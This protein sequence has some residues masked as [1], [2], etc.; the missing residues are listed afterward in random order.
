MTIRIAIVGVGWAGSRHAEAISELA[1]AAVGGNEPRLSLQ[2]LVDNDPAHLS[3]KATEFA[4]ESTSTDLSDA[5]NSSD[6][7]AVSIATPHDLHAPQA[8]AAAQAGKHVIV[9]KPMA[10]TV[11]D[12]TRMIDAADVNGVK[13]YVAENVTYGAMTLTLKELVRAQ[14]YTGPLT[15][16]TVIAGFRAESYGFP[17]RRAWLA[18]PSAGGSGTWLLH[19]VHTV[20]Q[21][22]AV[23]GD[24]ASVYVQESHT[25]DFSSPELE[26]TMSVLLTMESG[27]SVLFV[28]S[29]ETRFK[30]SQIGYTL[31][32]ERGSIRADRDR[33]EV[34]ST[35]IDP[36]L[37]EPL[38]L[39]Y[40]SQG[41]SEYALEFEAFAD[42][43]EHGA[44]GPTTGREERKS[45]AIVQAGYES[46]DIGQPINLRER[47]GDL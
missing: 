44:D 9:E 19:G 12:A 41:L 32:G 40:P 46:V 6:I 43:V 14:K 25:P 13:L 11:E 45:L 33:I 37:E 18:Q 39:D 35:E 29:C 24:A 20:A 21:L 17:G 2:M 23:L 5:L 7:D 34:Y 36:D 4:V 28:Q 10:V 16:A 42:H 3:D 22:R 30:R 15:F 31:F 27:L 38:M 1:H 8:I 26:G 47:F